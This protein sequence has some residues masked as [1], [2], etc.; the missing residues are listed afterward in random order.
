MIRCSVPVRRKSYLFPL[1]VVGK[2]LMRSMP[3]CILFHDHSNYYYST[4]ILHVYM[5]YSLD[6]ILWT[7]LGQG[8][9]LIVIS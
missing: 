6:T 4:I 5:G 9:G 2:G 7:A 1:A 3:T 8:E